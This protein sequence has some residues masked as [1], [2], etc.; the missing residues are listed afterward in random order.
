MNRFNKETLHKHQSTSSE[1]VCYSVLSTLRLRMALISTVSL[2]FLGKSD[3]HSQART[4]FMG[5][6]ALLLSH[7]VAHSAW[8][9]RQNHFVPLYFNYLSSDGENDVSKRRVLQHAIKVKLRVT[10]SSSCGS[11]Q[12]RIPSDEKCFI[13]SSRA[14]SSGFCKLHYP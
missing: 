1:A 6:S 2:P 3:L 8:F 11:F 9:E 5:S 4:D 7:A 10:L 12:I 14:F 13:S